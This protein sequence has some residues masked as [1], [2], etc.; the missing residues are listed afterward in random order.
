V[1]YFLSS[2]ARLLADFSA[3]IDQNRTITLIDGTAITVN[4]LHKNVNTTIALLGR[5]EYPATVEAMPAEPKIQ[6]ETPKNGGDEK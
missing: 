2:L 5:R 1:T 3:K 6:P 4:A